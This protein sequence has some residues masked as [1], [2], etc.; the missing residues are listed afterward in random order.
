MSE[1]PE[2]LVESARTPSAVR[3]SGDPLTVA[4]I[5]W[6][7]PRG[8]SLRAAMDAEMGALYAE[9]FASMPPESIAPM[10]QAFSIDPAEI[11]S[12]VVVLDG[13]LAVGHA[14]LRPYGDQLEVKR[15]FVRPE[16]R[17]RGVS[18]QLMREL[19]IIAR[20]GGVRTLVLQTADLQIDA[21]RLYEGLGYVPI[22]SF[23]G[24]D[25]V[26]GSLCFA[27]ELF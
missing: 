21:I 6:D 27:K 10:Q 24:Y 11:V 25:V 4:A 3:P 12:S 9:R 13:D 26:P 15:V 20:S 2:A 17:G 23:R 19:E 7:D 1:V 5:E 16:F 14:A 22:P 8:E 18:K